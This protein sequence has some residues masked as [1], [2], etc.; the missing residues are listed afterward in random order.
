MKEFDQIKKDYELFNQLLKD[1]GV[2]DRAM[3]K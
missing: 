1:G 2:V 3:I